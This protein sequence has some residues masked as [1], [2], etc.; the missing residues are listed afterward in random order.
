MVQT[1]AGWRRAKAP[2]ESLDDC[3]FQGQRRRYPPGLRPVRCALSHLGL[4]T[5]AVVAIRRQQVQG[6]EQPQR[7]LHALEFAAAHTHNQ[8]AAAANRLSAPAKNLTQL[9]CKDLMSAIV[10]PAGLT[11]FL[12]GFKASDALLATRIIDAA[13][14]GERDRIWLREAGVTGAGVSPV[15]KNVQSALNLLADSADDRDSRGYRYGIF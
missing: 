7:E 2:R 1:I 12:K 10:L 15:A 14:K 4:F 9:A 13:K 6:G 5:E 3:G 11:R 8:P